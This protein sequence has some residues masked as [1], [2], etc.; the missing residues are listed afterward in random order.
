MKYFIIFCL[1]I[2]LLFLELAT[3]IPNQKDCQTKNTAPDSFFAVSF[4]K[5]D[6][7]K[8]C[9]LSYVD[10]E[11]KTWRV[12][13]TAYSKTGYPMYNGEYPYEGVIAIKLPNPYGWK[14]GDIFE[15]DGKKYIAKDRL[16]NNSQADIDIFMNSLE[17]AKKWG[18]KKIKIIKL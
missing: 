9:W 17:E 5:D 7:D 2:Y 12:I 15:I 1:L 8:F 11:N 3:L 6:T 18:K 14:I 13:A 10:C 4:N 16:P